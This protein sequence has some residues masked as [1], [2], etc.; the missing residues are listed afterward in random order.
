M[1]NII[2][3]TEEQFESQ[4]LQAGG[5]VLVDFTRRGAGRAKRPRR[6]SWCRGFLL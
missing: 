4:V 1:K 6:R 3:L 5:P 2:E